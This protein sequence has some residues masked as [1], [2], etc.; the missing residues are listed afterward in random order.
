MGNGWYRGW[1]RCPSSAALTAL[2]GLLVA[3]VGGCGGSPAEGDSGTPPSKL[4]IFVYD[5]SGSMSDYQL[6]LAQELT[7]RRV[8]QLD[9]GDRIVAME[10]L[11]ASLAEPPQRWSQRVPDREY[12]DM[13]VESDSLARDR[14]LRD[15]V[16]Y[17]RNFTE[18][19]SREPARG[20]D[21]L[22]TLHD[23]AADLRAHSDHDAILYLFS[24]MLQANATLNFERPGDEPPVG[25][26]DKAVEEDRLPDLQG[27]C[28]VAVGARTDTQQ[29]QAVKDFWMRYFEG[30]GAT[31]RSRNYMLRPVELP[32]NPCGR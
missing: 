12:P 13:R 26:V 4:A 15:A 3:A 22:S 8:R 24:D 18:T 17:M 14:F 31:L 23:V 7:S 19:D 28:V 20:T 25:W 1:K 9:H 10:L 5:R 11:E 27:L 6:E 29:G 2:A 16:T 32:E 21:I 30:T